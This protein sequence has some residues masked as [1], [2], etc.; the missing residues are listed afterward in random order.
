LNVKSTL[1]PSALLTSAR[2][3]HTPARSRAGKRRI[4]SNVKATSFP[5]NGWPSDH[6]IPGRIANRAARLPVPHV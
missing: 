4:R 2:N 1:D 5:E 6:R 3:P